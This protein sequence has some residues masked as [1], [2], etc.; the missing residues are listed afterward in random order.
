MCECYC[1]R[2][3]TPNRH[4]ALEL[5]VEHLIQVAR[6]V[7]DATRYSQRL[8]VSAISAIEIVG[9]AAVN[10]P[11]LHENLLLPIAGPSARLWNLPCDDEFT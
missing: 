8:S 2:K 9:I 11:G 1:R 4:E 3:G 7:Q 5:V 6:D 10:P